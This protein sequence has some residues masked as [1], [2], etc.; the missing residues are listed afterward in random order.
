MVDTPSSDLGSFRK[1][2]DESTD[3]IAVHR[4]DKIIYANPA[5]L[6]L[7]G[8]ERLDQVL[9]RSPFDFVSPH[10]RDIVA[11]RIFKEYAGSATAEIEERM[12]H[13]SGR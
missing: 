12:L 7:F 8:Y 3:A 1:L 4:D 9:G 13:A 2:L 11:R 10:Y 5:A 6:K